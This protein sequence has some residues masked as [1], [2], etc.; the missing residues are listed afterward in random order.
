MSPHGGTLLGSAATGAP[1]D[2]A[3]A[4]A[5]RAARL[6]GV[7]ITMPT[8]LGELRAAA[9]VWQRV[10]SPEG[11][12]PV[13][14]EM[15]R[16]L[17]HAGNYLSVA[18]L[19][20]EVAGALLA[21]FGAHGDNGS[22]RVDR[23]HSHI[24]GVDPRRHSHGVGHALKL[25]QRAW[26][27][28]R[29]IRCMSWTFDPL[30][31][32]NGHFNLVK[33]GARGVEYLVDFYGAMPDAINGGDHTDR[34]LIEWDL[35]T[36]AD[37]D[38]PAAADVADW[39]QRGAVMALDAAADGSPLR[40]GA[41]PAGAGAVLC[42]TPPDIVEMRRRDPACAQRWRIALR[43]SMLDAM[44]QGMRLVSMARGGYYVLRRDAEDAA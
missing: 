31:R 27:L 2:A 42:A 14:T 38:P 36:A 44:A 24:L 37:A 20:G 15:L 8:E 23:M 13:S 1:L 41:M 26:A 4:A 17:T 3:R 30:V 19:D 25:H 40:S 32:R 39:L 18:H 16:A 9:A 35:T 33:L 21:F 6:A 28:E 5:D 29:D 43:E 11:E 12:P 7:R 22:T 34:I 10:W